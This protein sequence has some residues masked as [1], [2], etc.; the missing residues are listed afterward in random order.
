ML[1]IVGCDTDSA[2]SPISVSPDEA[3]VHRG[4]SVTFTV[5]GGYDYTWSLSQPEWGTLSTKSGPQTVYTSLYAPASNTVGIQILTVESTIEGATGSATGTGSNTTTSAGYYEKAEVKIRHLP[6]P[7][8]VPDPDISVSPSSLA[9]NGDEAV[10]TVTGGRA[11]YRWGVENGLRGHIKAGSASGTTS[12]YVRDQPG[13]NW[14]V[15][16]D[17][18]GVVDR[19]LIA[20]P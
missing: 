12:V 18:A 5:S 13:N 17:S 10:L 16:T 20:Q 8:S 3:K 15:V 14:A 1:V 6:D 4:E 19:V 7:A 9:N 11:P 2:T